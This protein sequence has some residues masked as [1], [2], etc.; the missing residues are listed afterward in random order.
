MRTEAWRTFSGKPSFW[1]AAGPGTN[2]VTTPMAIS[3]AASQVKY[4]KRCDLWEVGYGYDMT[5]PRVLVPVARTMSGLN[6]VG[7]LA[8]DKPPEQLL[9][10]RVSRCPVVGARK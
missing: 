5:F 2:G 10:H 3:R 9:Q 7:A 1:A 6:M 4:L 8:T